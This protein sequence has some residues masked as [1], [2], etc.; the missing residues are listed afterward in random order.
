MD[1]SCNRTAFK[2]ALVG[3]A[4]ALAIAVAAPGATAQGAG[5]V[6]Q[7]VS[8]GAQPL[9]DA[10]IAL[11]DSFGITVLANENLVAG[12]SAPAVSGELSAQ[13]AIN[14]LLDGSGL[15]ARPNQAGDFIVSQRAGE[16]SIP[17]ERQIKENISDAEPLVADPLIADRIIVTG[18][19]I[20]RSLKDTKE[21]VAVVTADIARARTLLSIQDA[22]LQTPNVTAS[23][24]NGTDVTIRGVRGAVG[25]ASAVGGS[26]D[27]SI[28]LY[29]NVPFS[30]IGRGFIPENFW[31]V[32]QVEY[33]RG[34]Q[35]TNLGRSA[36]AG[37]V[38]VRTVVPDPDAFD[39]AVR[40]EYGNFN[41][42]AAEGMLN[43]PISDTA[44]FRLTAERSETEGFISNDI[45]GDETGPDSLNI[46][47]RL[48]FEPNNR[49]RALASVQYLDE[50][51]G[52]TEYIVPA[53]G[54][55]ESFDATNDDPLRFEYEGVISSLELDYQLSDQW[56]LTSITSFLDAEYDR[57]TDIDRTL[58][59]IGVRDEMV[60]EETL[61]Q[62]VRLTYEAERL[63]GAIG[64]FYL[65]FDSDTDLANITSLDVGLAGAPAVL[66]PFYA[67]PT[68]VTGLGDT[69]GSVTNAAFFTQW[70][71]DLT[72]KLRLSAGLRY[73]TESIERDLSLVGVVDPSTPLPDPAVAAQIAEAQQPGTGALV[74]GGVTQVNGLLLS[75]APT[76]AEAFETDYEAFL[77][78]LGLTYALTPDT[79]VSAFYKRGY[80]AGGA[81][82]LAD[83]T[84]NTYDPE[85]LDNFEVSLRSSLLNG[86]LVFNA[87]AYY[88]V[89]TDQQIDVPIGGDPTNLGTLNVG[90]SRLWGV[91]AQGDYIIS[92]RT[93]VFASVGYADTE[94]TEACRIGSTFTDL[95]DCEI[96]GATGKDL[97]GNDFPFAPNWTASIGMRHAF[98]EHWFGQVNA[99]YQDGIF[100][101]VENDP[102][103]E[104][105]GY[106]LLNASFG[107]EG[108]RFALTVYGRNLADEFATRDIVAGVA[109]GALRIF[110]IRPRTYGVIVSAKF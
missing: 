3:V 14:R 58:L 65:T 77:P 69:Q 56:E 61:T 11:S 52:A 30:G 47:G 50:R 96:D 68:L 38:I 106:A 54:D 87:N 12:K 107:Y 33:L 16:P 24:Q 88:G 71:F 99:T 48:L 44:A 108:E 2:S 59:P 83:A 25:T 98:A 90:E 53:G 23:G 81:Q 102:Q 7:N 39:A 66:V 49:F 89:W 40:F 73:D 15:V 93:S 86:A 55:L 35:S 105:D 95:P 13:D 100:S 101:D 60:D 80:R 62:E 45:I 8:I 72:D 109:P 104:S 42:Y 27:V 32:E 67:N 9:G 22:A 97:A 28:A 103:F 41:T 85:Y 36:L 10:L 21:S 82:V 37:A 4:S 70:E 78:E 19:K 79:N 64:G 5:A 92:D 26:G 94:F 1:Q 74:A 51:S 31:D 6:G 46:R 17:A 18:Q 43:I 29:D 57:F 20:E 75:F 76:A 34:P 63:R 84:L 110:P 91:E